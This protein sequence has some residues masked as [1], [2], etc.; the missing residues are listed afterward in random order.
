M[1]LPEKERYVKV[2]KPRGKECI[3]IPVMGHRDPRGPD[4]NIRIWVDE[5]DKFHIRVEKTNRCY[6]FE[7]VI[8][9]D[10]YIEIV[11]K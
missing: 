5:N 3:N 7:K 1:S 6:Q 10:G 8:E 11:A 9:C 2:I 4:N